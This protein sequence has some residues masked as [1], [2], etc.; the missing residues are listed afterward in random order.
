M[1]H[2]TNVWYMSD[3]GRATPPNSPKLP[4]TDGWSSLS[5]APQIQVPL[6]L[7]VRSLHAVLERVTL[8]ILCL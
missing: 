2:I 5:W 8:V 4:E 1:G 6:I 7:P 3:Q